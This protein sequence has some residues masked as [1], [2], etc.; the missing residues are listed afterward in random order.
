MPRAKTPAGGL[1]QSRVHTDEKS[2]FPHISNKH[3]DSETK[4]KRG[5]H[6]YSV[7]LSL[8]STN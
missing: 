1:K 6:K 4:G 8:H 5:N 7:S 3:V 2:P